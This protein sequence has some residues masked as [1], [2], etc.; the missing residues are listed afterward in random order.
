MARARARARDTRLF[1]V[2]LTRSSISPG[3]EF[4]CV[5]LVPQ[6]VASCLEI[7]MRQ[8]I[9]R[10]PCV[11]KAGF[12]FFWHRMS[13]EEV[14]NPKDTV[15]SSSGSLASYY[16]LCLRCDY[17]REDRT[18]EEQRG[19]TTGAESKQLCQI[20]L[21]RLASGKIS[22]PVEMKLR[23][24]RKYSIKLMLAWESVCRFEYFPSPIP[25]SEA[26][27]SHSPSY[28]SWFR[29][30][31]LISPT[32]DYH[33]RSRCRC[34]CNHISCPSPDICLPWTYHQ[35]EVSRGICSDRMDKA[36]LWLVHG[37]LS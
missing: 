7:V 31:I 24:H 19:F 15:A 27:C 10:L 17:Q 32:R 6:N 33:R 8:H 35:N 18:E 9:N 21:L 22:H 28:S 13:C 25:H 5:W 16:S 4:H 29:D 23:L 12:V 34:L 1:V 37:A 3:V 14:R 36:A 11:R 30:S 20:Q 2:M 26:N